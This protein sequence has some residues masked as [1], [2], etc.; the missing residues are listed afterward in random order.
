MFLIAANSEFSVSTGA[1]LKGFL[2]VCVCVPY[3]RVA[4]PS[5]IFCACSR[6]YLSIQ[7]RCEG[8]VLRAS[9]TALCHSLASVL[10]CARRSRGVV[11]CVGVGRTCPCRGVRVVMMHA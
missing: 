1:D 2:C 6:V 11:C 3:M 5:A 7:S 9:S 10:C 8:G 4:R